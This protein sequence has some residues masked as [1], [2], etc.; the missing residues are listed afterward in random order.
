MYGRCVVAMNN[1]FKFG[2]AMKKIIV[3]MMLICFYSSILWAI[4]PDDINNDGEIA[5]PIPVGKTGQTKC[6][7]AGGNEISCTGTGQDGE[8]QKGIS[9]ETLR[10]I[11]P[12][13]GTVADN[14][15]GL[16]WLQNANNGSKNWADALSYCNALNTAGYDDWRLPNTNELNSLIDR[17][18][19]S[20][21]LP[22]GHP[23]IDVQP[24]YYWSGTTFNGNN[25]CVWRVNMADGD[26]DPCF[27]KSYS[28]YVWP[29]RGGSD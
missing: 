18:N 1:Y 12:G 11:I 13:D 22:S 3:L 16:T 9:N 8:L 14:N 29:V 26:I 6:Y 27:G 25:L 19:V 20:P 7:D 15:T 28:S 23:F 5:P 10:F 2:I 21:A 17:S 24:F 4:V